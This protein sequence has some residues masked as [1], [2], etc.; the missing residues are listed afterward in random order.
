MESLTKKIIQTYFNT[1]IFAALMQ[2]IHLVVFLVALSRLWTCFKDLRQ[3]RLWMTIVMTLLF[4]LTTADLAVYWA[5]VRH[6]FIV[7]GDSPES[8]AGA[9]NEY[10]TWFLA[11]NVFEA[12]NVF[13][14]DCVSIWRTFVVFGRKWKV[15]MI[16]IVFTVLTTGM[17][18]AELCEA[19]S[20]TSTTGFL[21][22]FWSLML[23]TPIFCTTSIIYRLIRA[24]GTRS[25]AT[26]IKI[27]V[28]SAAL[29]C[30]ATLFALISFLI[31]GPPFEYA[32][33]F[34]KACTGIAPTLIVARMVAGK[35]GIRKNSGFTETEEHLFS[36][37]NT[38]IR[39][40]AETR[41]YIDRN[42]S[43]DSGKG[44]AGHASNSNS[45]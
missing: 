27:L 16:P 6:A 38:G 41:T 24:G 26:I 18:I 40:H 39:V 42:F 12:V 7:H 10:P 28:E 36:S 17:S 45:M 15:I 1:V 34:W 31:L 13:L 35:S 21:T 30:F 22:A 14:A 3:F 23:V 44:V 33:T 25:Y 5:Y 20:R 43:R 9:L 11:T 19:I 37:T 8:I 4:V 29:Y 32:F 2:G